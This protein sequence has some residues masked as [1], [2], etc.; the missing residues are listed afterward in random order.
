M[1]GSAVMGDAYYFVKRQ[2]VFLVLGFVVAWW[3]SRRSPSQLRAMGWAALILAVLLLVATF[4]PLGVVVSGNRNWLQIPGLSFFRIQPS[5][6]AK[7]AM[8]IWGADIFARRDRELDEPLKILVP[9]VPVCLLLAGLVALEHDLGTSI[10]MLGI[11]LAVLWFAGIP[12]RLLVGLLA[13]AAAAVGLL[14]LTSGNRMARIF[15][16]L[17]P[18]DGQDGMNAQSLSSMYALA[19][20]G[21][22]GRGLGNSR[23]KWG[24]LAEAHTD[25]V[26]A[27]LGE[28]LGLIGALVVVALFVVL[29][30]VGIRIALRSDNPFSRLA[31]AG[32]TAWLMIQAT[33]NLFV[34]L[35]LLPVIGVPLPFI[36]Y[37]GA[38][39]LTNLMAIGVLLACARNEPDARR[40]LQRRKGKM[41]KLTTIVDGGRR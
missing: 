4:T 40:V 27:I 11:M 38:A 39:L 36:S 25:F 19:S 15:F 8:I 18:T 34:V 28:E 14:V 26:F 2:A 21:W 1:F 17:N 41:P 6:F 22:W 9:Y 7:V 16:F 13:T 37:G 29:G 24:A 33:I 30:L 20:G 35:R 3:L 31:A 23:Q 12:L 10:V 32:V 5:E